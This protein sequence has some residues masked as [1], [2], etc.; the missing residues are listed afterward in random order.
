VTLTHLP[1]RETI[2]PA[3]YAALA[4]STAWLFAWQYQ[5]PSY[6]AM[7]I[8]LLIL[9]PACWLDWLVIARLT[10]A[11]IALMPGNPTPLQNPV[12]ARIGADVLT[13][14]APIVVAS[15]LGALVAL[16][17]T[18]RYRS[19]PTVPGRTLARPVI[20]D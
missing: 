4:L 13:L 10:A 12:L 15:A 8:C 3:S 18:E 2:P 16:C 9:A 20:A 19:R 14:A 17:L 11:T 7:V 5:L 1:G 6:E